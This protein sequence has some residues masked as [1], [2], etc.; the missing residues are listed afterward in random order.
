[1]PKANFD[2]SVNFNDQIKDS[3]KGNKI[4]REDKFLSKKVRFSISGSCING[5]FRISNAFSD[6]EITKNLLKRLGE[7]EELTWS[8]FQN[9]PHEIGWSTERGGIGNNLSWLKDKYPTYSTFGHIRVKTPKA[10]KIFRIFCAR[11]EDLV[12]LLEFD[13]NGEVNH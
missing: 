12:Y 5:R 10:K 1:M 6:K 8:D 11:K 7:I 3:Y 4:L 2:F 9:L 13:V